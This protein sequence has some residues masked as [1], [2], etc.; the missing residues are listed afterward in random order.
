MAA[1]QTPEASS[2][3]LLRLSAVEEELA[4]HKTRIDAINLQIARSWEY[5]QALSG[6]L[7]HITGELNYIRRRRAALQATFDRRCDFAFGLVPPTPEPAWHALA[8]SLGIK[9]ASRRLL[10]LFPYRLARLYLWWCHNKLPA[11]LAC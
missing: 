9:R 2:E 3:I 6:D 11:Y 1:H 7:N 10:P 4:R 5:L 8:V